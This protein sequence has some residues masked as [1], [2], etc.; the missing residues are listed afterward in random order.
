MEEMQIFKNE[1]LG[2]NVRTLKNEDGSISVNAEDVA[3]GYGWVQ[4]DIKNGKTYT[5]VKWA[6]MNGFI[7]DL[8]FD[9]KCTKDNYIPESLFYLLGMKA[10]NETA[11]RFQ[12]WLAVDV[13]PSIRKHGAYMTEDTLDNALTS[14]DFLIKL[15]TKLKEEKD[16][17]KQLENKIEEYK[18][19]VAKVKAIEETVNCIPFGTYASLLKNAGLNIGQNT[20]FEWCRRNKLLVKQIGRKNHPTELAFKLGVFALNQDVRLVKGRLVTIH[21]TVITSKGQMYLLGK[22]VKDLG[23]KKVSVSKETKE[24]IISILKNLANKSEFE[25]ALFFLKPLQF[26]DMINMLVEFANDSFERTDEEKYLL[27]ADEIESMG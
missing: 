19:Y 10:S 6:R 22:I 24:F 1:E 15:A 8:G 20:L 17:N 4:T 13:I 23:L 5:S 9:H 12:R 21:K 14:P 26:D 7:S 11:Q 3:I 27:I 18:P 16:K 2:L 25:I